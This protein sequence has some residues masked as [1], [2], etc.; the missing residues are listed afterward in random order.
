MRG[1]VTVI[2]LGAAAMMLAGCAA[3]GVLAYKVAGPAWVEAKYVPAKTPMLILVENH[4]QPSMNVGPDVLTGYLTENLTDNQ[5]GPLVPPEKLQALRDS[6]PAEYATMSIS[7]IG[8]AVGASQ[9][10]YV[11]FTHDDATPLEGGEAMTGKASTI[12]KMVDAVTGKT[13]WPTDS[14]N[15]YPISSSVSLS[16]ERSHGTQAEIHRR[17]YTDLADRISRLFY[18]WQPE[19]DTPESFNNEMGG[20]GSCVGSIDALIH[21]F[22]EGVVKNLVSLL[23]AV[24]GG[25]GDDQGN[26]A[27]RLC[28]SA[29][30]AQECGGDHFLC[31]CGLKGVKDIGAVAAGAE[32]D[33]NVAG[34][35]EALDLSG[36][37]VIEAEVVGGAGDGG[38]VAEREGGKSAA[39]FLEARDQLFGQVHGVGGAAAVAAGHD[40]AAIAPGFHHRVGELRHLGF[41][42]AQFGQ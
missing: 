42:V 6:R 18:R 35:A 12:V 19:D 10:L 29:V 13:L 39:I 37:D 32:G 30:R 31:F 25:G 16:S 11:E 1:V 21:P 3:F 40:F 36:E 20:A 34:I 23:N 5:I 9:V 24:G 14:S 15:G 17:L 27:K 41:E 26:V 38:G 7:A 28:F 22:A 33:E 8:K 4:S 2:V